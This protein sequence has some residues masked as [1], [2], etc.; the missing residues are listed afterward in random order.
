MF[1]KV[2]SLNVSAAA[3]LMMFEMAR[4]RHAKGGVIE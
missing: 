1:G 4:Q 3:A 2:D